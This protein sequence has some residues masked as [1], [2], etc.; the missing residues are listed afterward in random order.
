MIKTKHLLNISEVYDGRQLSPL[1]IYQNHGL[2]G[3]SLVS[4]IGP[5]KI[6]DSNIV[7]TEDLLNNQKIEGDLMLHFIGEFFTPHLVEIV[8]LQRLMASLI[9]DLLQEQAPEFFLTRSGDDLYF[10]DKKLSISIAT[11][12]VQSSVLHFALNITNKGT[13]V[14]TC[15]LE[16]FKINPINFASLV[17]SKFADEYTS[18]QNATYKVKSV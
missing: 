6:P 8:Y 2:L 14:K 10:D 4:W 15:S 7:D 9:K 1:W 11:R 12:A 17:L 5:C 16:D 13:P 3:T 18:S